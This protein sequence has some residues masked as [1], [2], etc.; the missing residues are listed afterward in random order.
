M[1]FL[2][3]SRREGDI[4]KTTSAAQL[5]FQLPKRSCSFSSEESWNS[6]DGKDARPPNCQVDRTERAVVCMWSQVRLL[7]KLPSVV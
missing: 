1:D 5:T 7:E 6:R 3:F 2:I 4:F